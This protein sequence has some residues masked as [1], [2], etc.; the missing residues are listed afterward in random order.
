VSGSYNP[1]P[2]GGI[3][4]GHLTKLV[5]LF[6][7]ALAIRWIY[8]LSIYAT[9]GEGGLLV[10]DS[11][12]YLSDARSMAGLITSGKL[13]G[14]KWLGTDISTMPVFSWL[15]TL[16]VLAFG[17]KSAFVYVMLQGALDAVTC[18]FV[19][20]MAATLK[21]KIALASG[22][23]AAINPTQIV[24][25]G[26]VYTDTPFLLFVAMSLYG[27]LRW[28]Q[29]PTTSAALIIAIGLGGALLTRI[30]IVPFIPVLIVFLLAVVLLRRSFT[31]R[32]LGHAALIAVIAALCVAPILLRNWTERNAFALTPQGG[33]HL[34]YWVVPLV[35]EAKDGTPWERT[36]AAMK[37]RVE[38]RR[39]ASDT[40]PF[41]E[42]RIAA[43]VGREALLELGY[44]AIAKAWAIGA[45]INL[46]SPAIILS[47]P[48][49]Q[50][51]RKGFYA[52]PGN[53]PAEKIFNF[54]FRSDNSYY[55]LALLLGGIG[56]AIVRLIQLT[57]LISL[58]R[59]VPISS[60]LLLVGWIGYIL[61]VNGP[62][63]SP[64]YRLPMEPALNVFTGAGFIA[65]RD[66]RRRRSRPKA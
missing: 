5:W 56:V 46:A 66:W 65:L 43:Q 63:A 36:A 16:N 40:D 32:H 18:L 26:I 52:T 38:E 60:V 51:P 11:T 61:A 23:A 10:G 37:K 28:L 25:A 57:G 29:R 21:E 48:V 64:K 9:M 39:P 12:G 49:L 31:L 50:L 62:V 41:Y 17:D 35:K 15:L 54:V 27:A 6:V 47:P 19:Y 22:I 44:S 13:A 4:A 2:Y 34:A 24:T 3:A 14:W 30:V 59:S 58:A 20:A 1:Q 53:T 8:T 33:M 7:F 45:A 42:T 55:A